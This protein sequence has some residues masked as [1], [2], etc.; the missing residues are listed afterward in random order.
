[1]GIAQEKK[2]L[3]RKIRA[4]RLALD[5]DLARAGSLSVTRALLG[6]PEYLAAHGVF[7]F[8]SALGEPDTAS[9]IDDALEAGK[10]VFVPRCRGGGLMDIVRITS[11][12]DLEPGTHGIYEP[13]AGLKDCGFDGVDLAVIPAMACTP[14]GDRLGQG[15]G[16]Y[17]RFLERYDGA[18]CALCYDEFVY[19]ELPCESH[20]RKMRI[21]ITPSG[22]IRIGG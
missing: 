21:V 11:R 18:Q 9:V 12:F 4:A 7:I 16:Y 19:P 1:M 20:D 14:G 15:G 13:V 17:D 5:A 3:R 6:L 22:V 2:A 10:A 8:V